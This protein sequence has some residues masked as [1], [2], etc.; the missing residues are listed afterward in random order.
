M[1]KAVVMLVG[2][3]VSVL[4]V[5]ADD[6]SADI[7]WT[8]PEGFSGQALNVYNWATYIGETTVADFEALCGV[9]VTYDNFANNDEMIARLRQGNPGYDVVF[10]NT[11]AIQLLAREGLVET[12]DNTRI[13][14]RANLGEAWSGLPYDPE[15]NL[16]VPYLWGTMGV[17]Y[18]I[19]VVEEKLGGPLTSWEQV[20]S[21]D[22]PVAWINDTRAMMSVGL[23]MLGFDPNSTVADEI[24]QAKDFLLA[25]SGNVVTIASDDGQT[26]LERGEVDIV[27]E[28]S[29]DMFQLITSCEC[30]TFGYLVPAEGSVVDMAAMFI[31]VDAPNALLAHAFMDFILDPAVNADIVTFTTYATPSQ[32]AIDSGFIA[33]DLLTNPAVFPTAEMMA[34]VWFND[35][36]SNVEGA[37]QAYSDAWDELLIS[38]GSS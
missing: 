11:Y 16:S 13:P 6:H 9:T 33:E 2:L 19:A 23:K 35:D 12:L 7:T 29:G 20:F 31:P 24:N 27:L 37:E 14:N 3:L 4:A 32:A 8:C 26:L 36:V 15:N 18:N 17:G 10:G 38:V 30:D 28:Y 34:S 5:Q 25:N 22:G 21:Y 1:K